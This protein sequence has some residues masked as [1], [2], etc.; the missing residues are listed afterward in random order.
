MELVYNEATQLFELKCHTHEAN[1]VQ[2]MGF[3]LN[4]KKKIWT[5]IDPDIAERAAAYA[6][7]ETRAHIDSRRREIAR[8]ELNSRAVGAEGASPSPAE[9][10]YLPYQEAG[11]RVMLERE[12]NLLGDEM[13]LGKTIQAIGVI[14]SRTEVESVL[15]I[16][17]ASLK[18]NWKRELEKWLTRR[19]TFLV[20]T[21]SFYPIGSNIVIINYELVK[22]YLEDLSS[23]R[24]DLI[25]GDEIH[26]C[27][28]RKAQRTKATFS[29]SST[30]KLALSGTPIENR[31]EDL[32]PVL[33]W[34]Q[35]ET[36]SSE[37][38][39]VRT[40]KNRVG[41]LQK[42]LRSTVMIRRLKS[43]VLTELP[44]KTRQVIELPAKGVEKIVEAEMEEFRRRQHVIQE[45]KWA[46]QEAKKAGNHEEYKKL[47]F[48]LN[49]AVAVLFTEMA[50]V[51]KQVAIAKTPFVIEHARNI[52]EQEKK[53]VVFAHHHEVLDRFANDLSDWQ[54]C[55]LD[56]RT[57]QATRD[58]NVEL[59]QTD[60][61]RHIFLG[62]IEAAGV[63]LTLTAARVCLF[64]ELVWKPSTLTQAEDRLHRIGQ[65]S[66]VL[67]QHAVLEKS[68][69]LHMAHKIITKQDLIDKALNYG[70]AGTGSN[71]FS[72][73]I[74]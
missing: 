59:F 45:L 68:L 72:N 54:P 55:V 23:R 44:P 4:D 42:D 28:N 29:L 63:G 69:D 36:W 3:S 12:N 43:E 26:Y 38:G 50:K 22:K 58:A 15:I 56:G 46:V 49:R 51:R 35:P 39:F 1:A 32:W 40:Y 30:Y 48:N 25:I 18:L 13:G 11:I 67:I 6:D 34:M 7:H 9:L 53:L 47:I 14:N 62:G 20:A 17:P 70:D 27:K 2:Q 5:A 64:A 65:Q 19:L 52:L 37:R 21:P 57:S 73:T 31:I 61:S 10:Q 33:H 8:V 41:Q 74:R 66:N 24:W 16:T 60:P 71:G